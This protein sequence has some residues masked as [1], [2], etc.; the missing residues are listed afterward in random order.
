VGDVFAF[1]F[2]I[3]IRSLLSAIVRFIQ[4]RKCLL[5]NLGRIYAL[6]SMQM[7]ANNLKPLSALYYDQLPATNVLQG[8]T[9][10]C[11][12]SVRSILCD[13]S[14]SSTVGKFPN[15]TVGKFPRSIQWLDS[16]LYCGVELRFLMWGKSVRSTDRQVSA[17]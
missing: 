15:S 9:L 11:E 4:L 6:Y 2:G 5:C 16:D 13:K 10:Y 7:S 14:L 3:S 8:S 1:Y 17:Y 12:A